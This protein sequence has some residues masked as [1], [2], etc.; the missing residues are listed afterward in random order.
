MCELKSSVTHF[1]GKISKQFWNEINYIVLIKIFSVNI[2]NT[3]F[4]F[5]F[6]LVFFQRTLCLIEL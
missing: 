4:K 2:K 5:L 3:D 1:S 6:S